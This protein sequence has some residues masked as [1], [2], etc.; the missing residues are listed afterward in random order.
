MLYVKYRDRE[1]CSFL[2]YSFCISYRLENKLELLSLWNVKTQ[3][4]Y[5]NNIECKRNVEQ[6]NAL[7]L[8][9]D[10]CIFSLD[11]FEWDWQITYKIRITSQI[12]VLQLT[13]LFINMWEIELKIVLSDLPQIFLTFLTISVR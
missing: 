2:M 6:E 7:S 3:T 5:N 9:S 10:H 11:S 12:F 13:S 8:K 1:Y 4:I